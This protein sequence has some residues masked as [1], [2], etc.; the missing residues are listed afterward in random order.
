MLDS[1]NLIHSKSIVHR[2]IKPENFL[3]SNNSSA[4]LPFVL[5]LSDLGIASHLNEKISK[6]K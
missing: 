5:K 2:D 3:I 1:V 6:S 4:D